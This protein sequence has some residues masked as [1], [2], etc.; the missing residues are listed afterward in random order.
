V[1]AIAGQQ[2]APARPV[3]SPWLPR[4]AELVGPERLLLAGRL[5]VPRAA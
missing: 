2:R 4:A 5:V 1:L 3:A